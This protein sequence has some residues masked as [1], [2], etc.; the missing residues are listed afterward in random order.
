M[1]KDAGKHQRLRAVA[2]GKVQRVNFR[3]WTEHEARA[4]GLAGWVRNLSS[5]RSVE[6]LA[7]GPRREL[8]GLRTFLHQGPPYALVSTVDVEWTQAEGGLPAPF[9]VR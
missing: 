1:V 9:R 3:A 5:G 2:H 8:D 6:V 7:E 4:L